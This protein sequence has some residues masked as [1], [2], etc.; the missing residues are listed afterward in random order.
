MFKYQNN[1]IKVYSKILPCNAFAPLFMQDNA[2]RRQHDSHERSAVHANVS[3]HKWRTV[4]DTVL[5]LYREAEGKSQ[6]PVHSI[7]DPLSLR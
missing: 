3:R 5:Q 2:Q 4:G 1:K 7:R 6:L